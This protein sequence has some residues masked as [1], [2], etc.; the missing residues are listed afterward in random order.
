LGLGFVGVQGLRLTFAG[1]RLTQEPVPLKPV[2]MSILGEH[3]T[4]FCEKRKSDGEIPENA[5]CGK[6]EM[7]QQLQEMAENR[8]AGRKVF[9]NVSSPNF[10]TQIFN[11]SDTIGTALISG[12]A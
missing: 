4:W 7:E 10:W 1:A 5:S 6:E 2:E 11:F 8:Q 9:N 3:R 12:L